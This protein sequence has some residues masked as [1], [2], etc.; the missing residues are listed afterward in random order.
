[1]YKIF[2]ML[3]LVI[4][5]H[6]QFQEFK[7]HRDY[8]SNPT[9]STSEPTTLAEI[10]TVRADWN[11]DLNITVNGSGNVTNW[12]DNSGNGYNLKSINPYFPLH[13]SLSQAGHHAVTFDAASNE[14]L[15]SLSGIGLTGNPNIVV[16]AV[17]KGTNSGRIFHIGDSSGSAGTVLIT[18]FEDESTPPDPSA[19][20]NN[21]NK[22][23][24]NVSA[25]TNYS[26]LIWK[27]GTNYGA[28]ELWQ[29]GAKQTSTAEANPTNTVNLTSEEIKVGYGRNPSAALTAYFSGSILRLVVMDG[30]YTDT[31]IQQMSTV[32]NNEYVIY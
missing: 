10:G 22:R 15:Y 25:V 30:V 14:R 8:I 23:W 19:R 1:M 12:G 20:W 13:D 3:L 5:A 16:I 29:N 17:V 2:L 28:T 21:G 32:M 4:Q 18:S 7:S 31:E 24:Q 6:G 11:G 9:V 26:V 27:F